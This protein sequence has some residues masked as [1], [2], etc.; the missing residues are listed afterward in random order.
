M[1]LGETEQAKRDQRAHLHD[2][3][4][5]AWEAKS[6]HGRVAH[7]EPLPAFASLSAHRV[8]GPFADSRSE[9]LEQ[10][11][12]RPGQFQFSNFERNL[13]PQRDERLVIRLQ[14]LM[15]PETFHR[16]LNRLNN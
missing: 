5:C 9:A 11:K 1:T 10:G 14:A 4:P 13:S 3:I 2:G 16:S 7:R 15:Q 6:L 8:V 12:A